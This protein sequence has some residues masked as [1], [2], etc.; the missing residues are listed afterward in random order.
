VIPGTLTLITI[1]PAP[2]ASTG[3]SVTPVTLHTT[4][5]FVPPFMAVINTL[6]AQVNFTATASMRIYAASGPDTDKLW[7]DYQAKAAVA[8]ADANLWVEAR[9][10]GS[11]RGFSGS[12]YS[13][14][15]ESDGE[16][17]RAW[18]AWLEAS[19]DWNRQLHQFAAWGGEPEDPVT[20]GVS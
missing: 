5:L 14:L 10:A 18:H 2:S 8:Q 19:E 15:W 20:G 7:A 16:A 4:S 6:L 3:S 9:I 1:F 17:Q 11:S 13:G 12:Y